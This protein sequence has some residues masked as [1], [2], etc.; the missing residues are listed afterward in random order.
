MIY[1]VRHGLS[2]AN[3]RRVFAGQKDDSLL[4]DKGR[5]QARETAKKIKEEGIEIHKIISS[6]SKRAH[7]TAQIIASELGFDNSD[8]IIDERIIE[9]DMGSLS[10]TPWHTISSAILVKA[11]NAEN[12]KDFRNR[13]YSCMKELYQLPENVLLVSHAGVGRMLDTI[14]DGKMSEELFY[15]KE[16]YLNGSITK[17]DWIK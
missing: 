5:D 1:F 9:Y 3:V 13:V 4:V 8:I 16:A 10:G 15:D 12:P 14:K 7:E 6:P 2:E 17:I 11:Q